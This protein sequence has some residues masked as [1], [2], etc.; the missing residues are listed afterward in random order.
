MPCSFVPVFRSR[1]PSHRRLND[2]PSQPKIQSALSH[3]AVMDG[4]IRLLAPPRHAAMDCIPRTIS[5][6]Q[7][8][9]ALSSMSNIAGYRYQ[10]TAQRSE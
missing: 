5:R 6:A 9:D 1:F 3:S 2:S 8:F 4:P 7:T 10:S